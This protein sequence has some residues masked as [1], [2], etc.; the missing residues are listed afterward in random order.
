MKKTVIIKMKLSLRICL[1]SLRKPLQERRSRRMVQLSEPATGVTGL[2]GVR[3]V[4]NGY[5]V[6]IDKLKVI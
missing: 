6:G 3:E 5:R 4:L 2:L 1:V